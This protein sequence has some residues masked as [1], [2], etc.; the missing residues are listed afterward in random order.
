M[1][2]FVYVFVQRDKKYQIK[3]ED[4]PRVFVFVFVFVQRDKKI[5]SRMKINPTP[6]YPEQFH[7]L[8]NVKSWN[9]SLQEVKWG[10]NYKKLGLKR[11]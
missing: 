8:R 4:D 11:T 3:D 10:N 2:V 9:H 1:F 5:K 6:V 7:Q